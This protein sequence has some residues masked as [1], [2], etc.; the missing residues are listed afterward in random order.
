M[1]AP[2]RGRALELK[3]AS[4]C[5]A[6]PPASGAR[7]GAVLRCRRPPGKADYGRDAVVTRRCWV[8]SRTDRAT[9]HIFLRPLQGASARPRAK[10]T[11][12]QDRCKQRA[13]GRPLDCRN[14][15]SLQHR[16]RPGPKMAASGLAAASQPIR[17][18]A[19][20]RHEPWGSPR[21]PEPLITSRPLLR[22]I[23]SGPVFEFPAAPGRLP[24]GAFEM[25]S[26]PLR[27]AGEDG[28]RSG[29]QRSPPTPRV[30]SAA[31]LAPSGRR[32]LAIAVLNSHTDKCE[33]EASAPFDGKR[34]AATTGARSC[35]GQRDPTRSRPFGGCQGLREPGTSS[36]C[37]L[38]MSQ[39]MPATVIFGTKMSAALCPCRLSSCP[40][41][42][43]SAR[44]R[45]LCHDRFWQWLVEIQYEGAPEEM[46]VNKPNRNHY[47]HTK[48]ALRRGT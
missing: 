3:T 1:S 27:S 8:Q 22:D 14:S 25:A 37:H 31:L 32:G 43:A 48:R 13:R 40:P 7:S 17:C 30:L 5:A 19:W 47:T 23:P 34:G 16:C 35:P 12:P 29:R 36:L 10:L 46:D 41:E 45:G 9:T 28:A 21:S 26:D 15:T 42:A 38:R 44:A 33:L 11:G 6:P 39:L 18:G 2:L 4:T 24:D 20:D